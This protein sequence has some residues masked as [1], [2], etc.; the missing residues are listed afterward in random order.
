MK[1]NK[2]CI[3]EFDYVAYHYVTPFVHRWHCKI[4]HMRKGK[5]EKNYVFDK[6]ISEFIIYSALVNVI[7]PQ[8]NKHKFDCA[9][10]TRIM[11][12]FI[13]DRMEDDI[14]GQLSDP[15]NGLISI[16]DTKQFKVVSSSEKDPD[17]RN[18]WLSGNS[19][20][21]L[22]ALL[23]T[24]YYLRCNLFHGEKEYSDDQVSLLNPA[25]VCLSVINK[26]IEIIFSRQ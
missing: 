23:E 18:N 9:Y 7:K 1:K 24:L 21:Q 14:I 5:N 11:A 15:V 8:E 6:F 10:C 4:S 3:A 22:T 20:N 13:A 25:S 19:N 26:E 12:E 2:G 16:I 17:L